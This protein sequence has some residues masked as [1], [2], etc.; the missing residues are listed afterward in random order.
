MIF[1]EI[2]SISSIDSIT[3]REVHFGKNSL[4]NMATQLSNNI[5]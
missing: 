4:T 2:N 1:K 3:T 5:T